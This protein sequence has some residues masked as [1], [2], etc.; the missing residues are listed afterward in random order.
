[1]SEAREIPRLQR[2]YQDTTRVALQKEFG[3]ANLMQVPRL[4][5]IVIKMGVGEAAGD[6]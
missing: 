2:R 5:K 3:Y 1:M 4:D 6:P